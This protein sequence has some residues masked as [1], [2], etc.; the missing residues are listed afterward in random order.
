MTPKRNIERQLEDTILTPRE[1]CLMHLLFGGELKK[2]TAEVLT[3]GLDIDAENQNYILMLSCLGYA[4][5]WELFPPEIVPRLKGVHRYHQAH[6]SIGIPWLIRQL[7]TLSGA[8]IPIML[9]KGIAMRA[10]YAPNT[11]RLMWD[12]DIAVPEER[13]SEALQLLCVGE[14]TL[15][16]EYAHSGTVRY[17]N[18]ELDIH[19]WIFKTNGE[20]E[21]GIWDRAISFDFHGIDVCVPSPEDMLIH[22]MDTQSRNIF[23]NEGTDRRMK[24]LYDCR[25]I[26]ETA[27]GLNLSLIAAY[28][29]ELHTMNRMRL[30]LRL[31]MCCFPDMLGEDALNQAFPPSKGYGKWLRSGERYREVFEEYRKFPYD[32]SSALSPVHL[33][34]SLRLEIVSWRYFGPELKSADRKI[35]FWRY[36]KREKGIDSLSALL[37][38]YV[39]RVRLREGQL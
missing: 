27:G 17:R 8:G 32:E 6:N 1:K 34:R 20:K 12:Y 7:R 35:N 10:Y 22:Q 39:S 15:K 14:N 25:C 30:M 31:F 33:A 37:K 21:S 13:Y 4:R 9:L 18:E 5:G 29:E 38:K 36:V 23:T 3:E 24:W 16:E 26:L 2:E 28:A 11:P 19:R